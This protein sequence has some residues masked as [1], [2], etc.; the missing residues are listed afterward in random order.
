MIHPP[1]GINTPAGGYPVGINT[2]A[3][4]GEGQC[5]ALAWVA[6]ST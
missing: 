6:S 1:A 5:L 4:K 3:E 2:P